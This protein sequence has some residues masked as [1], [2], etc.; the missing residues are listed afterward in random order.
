MLV[1]DTMEKLKRK[2][3]VSTTQIKNFMKDIRKIIIAILEMI[4]EKSILGSSL[5]RA[6]IIFNPYLLLK[7]SKQKLSN[8]L[9]VL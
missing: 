5:V 9:K 6:A 7:L 8:H 1:L 3:V 4:F 2:N